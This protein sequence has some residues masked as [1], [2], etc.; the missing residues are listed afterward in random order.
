[1]HSKIYNIQTNV[2]PLG[3]PLVPNNCKD[4]DFAVHVNNFPKQ[5]AEPN[6]PYTSDSRK[7]GEWK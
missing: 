2:S 7:V 6:P 5:Y 1:M 4:V 3:M